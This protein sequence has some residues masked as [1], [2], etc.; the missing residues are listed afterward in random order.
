[1]KQTIASLKKELAAATRA[2]EEK[3]VLIA[4]FRNYLRPILSYMSRQ[5]PGDI[6]PLEPATAEGDGGR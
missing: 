2:C 1:M 3:D 6:A 5:W 4:R